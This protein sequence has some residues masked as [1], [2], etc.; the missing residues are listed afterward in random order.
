MRHYMERGGEIKSLREIK[1]DESGAEK[2]LTKEI[3]SY[4]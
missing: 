1:A 3:F 2:D 4:K